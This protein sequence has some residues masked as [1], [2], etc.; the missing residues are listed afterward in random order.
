MIPFA[1]KKIE[2]LVYGQ[3]N[4]VYNQTKKKSIALDLKF[5]VEFAFR[6]NIK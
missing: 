3:F 4:L 2:K 5:Y 6:Q 1:N